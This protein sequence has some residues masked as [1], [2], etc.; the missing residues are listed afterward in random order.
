MKSRILFFTLALSLNCISP[1]FC[2]E[3]ISIAAGFGF[4]ELLNL[5][6]RINGL[7]NQFAF[8]VGTFP[9]K[10][11]STFSISG[12]FYFH[13]GGHAKLVERRP[14]FGKIGLNYFR[15]ESIYLTEKYTYLNLGVGREFNLS[16]KLGIQFSAGTVFQLDEE[17]T[18]NQPNI[19]DD[20]I[21]TPVL[22]GLSFATFY[23]L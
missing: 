7:Q 1:T 9:K 17:I 21:S 22:P 6:V 3:K 15:A 19:W 18:F 23:K 11:E 2:Q 4:P 13:F 10:E 5:G 16:K 12:D 14:W 20:N 8:S